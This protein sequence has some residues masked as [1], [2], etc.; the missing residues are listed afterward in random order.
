MQQAIAKFGAGDAYNWFQVLHYHSQK[1]EI[2]DHP[3]PLFSV[4]TLWTFIVKSKLERHKKSVIIVCCPY[5][6][7]KPSKHATEAYTKFDQS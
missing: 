4:C 3:A 6:N 7:W 5:V 1:T 2:S